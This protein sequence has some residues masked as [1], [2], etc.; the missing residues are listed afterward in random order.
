M[1][2]ITASSGSG[3]SAL[4]RTVT[5]SVTATRENPDVRVNYGTMMVFGRALYLRYN[6]L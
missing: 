3:A 4:T 5:I 2:A 6:R 1:P